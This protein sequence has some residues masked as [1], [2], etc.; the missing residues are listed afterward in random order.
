MEAFFKNAP[1][2]PEPTKEFE[3]IDDGFTYEADGVELTSHVAWVEYFNFFYSKFWKNVYSQ[4]VMSQKTVETE[5]P[6]FEMPH[7]GFNEIS[8][9]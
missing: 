9:K 6:N 3:I 4:K 7:T 8:I 1:K 5:F 2:V